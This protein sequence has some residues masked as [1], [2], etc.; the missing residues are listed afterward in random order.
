MQTSST[1]RM[2][3]EVRPGQ[4]AC[5]IQ[6]DSTWW[7][8][9]SGDFGIQAPVASTLHSHEIGILNL[10]GCT[11]SSHTWCPWIAA[12]IV[13]S[14]SI[15]NSCSSRNLAVEPHFACPVKTNT[16]PV[17]PPSSE[18]RITSGIGFVYSHGNYLG[19]LWV[20]LSWKRWLDFVAIYRTLTRK[21]SC[22]YLCLNCSATINSFTLYW[23]DIV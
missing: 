20:F 17:V 21:L 10:S 11:A 1:T 22:L 5:Q 3:S 14:C 13:P 4:G 16:P 8:R 18:Y 19:F 12:P 6:S 2:R 15:C 7:L 9:W 23:H